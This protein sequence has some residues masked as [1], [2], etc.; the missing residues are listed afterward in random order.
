VF[1]LAGAL[2]IGLGVREFVTTQRFLAKASTA[3][4]VVV[5][6]DK[7]VDYQ[8]VGSG[9]ER[10]YEKVTAYYPVVRFV[11]AS[12]QVVQYTDDV[13]EDPPAYRVGDSVRVLYD[14]ANPQKA[15]LD[16]WS[17]RWLDATITTSMGIFFILV[18]GVFVM[19]TRES[20]RQRRGRGRKA[21]ARGLS[22][23]SKRAAA[24]RRGL[25][26]IPPRSGAK[27]TPPRSGAEPNW[28]PYREPA[29]D[30]PQDSRI[31]DE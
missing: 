29:D 30:G 17:S 5:R 20:P 22:P 4:G 16:T 15:R 7:V 19:L 10:T 24:R 28:P 1:V 21:P 27:P 31:Q 11:T 13:G 18:V 14:P 23:M 25:R 12:G 6:V 26:A 2:L 9:D 3:D 8:W